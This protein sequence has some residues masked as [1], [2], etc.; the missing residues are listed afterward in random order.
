MQIVFAELTPAF[1]N[2]DC[3]LQ[4]QFSWLW[5]A[6]SSSPTSAVTLFFAFVAMFTLSSHCAAGA[7]GV[8][9]VQAIVR[10]VATLSRSTG[11]SLPVYT[12]LNAVNENRRGSTVSFLANCFALLSY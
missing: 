11:D 2:H 3:A 12:E 4:T 6:N 1:R 5:K 8:G 10:C 9:G 7:A